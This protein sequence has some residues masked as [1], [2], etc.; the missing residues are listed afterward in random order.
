MSIPSPAPDVGYDV[1]LARE[2]VLSLCVLCS[3]VTVMFFAG[4]E[5]FLDGATRLICFM[6]KRR[7]LAVNAAACC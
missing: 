7:F 1:V 5:D 3:E 4:E 6:F 2:D